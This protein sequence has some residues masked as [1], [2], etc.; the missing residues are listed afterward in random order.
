MEDLGLV[1]V[2]G[3]GRPVRVDDQGPAPAV[4]DDLVVERTKQARSPSRTWCRRGPCAWCGAPGRRRRAGCSRRPTGSAGPAA[5]PRCGSPPGPSRRTRYPAAGSA[6]PAA[7][8]APGAAGSG[9]P[10]RPGDQVHRLADDRLLQGGPG[11][12]PRAVPAPRVELDAQPDQI[13]ER[14]DVDV[15]GDDRGH[16]GVAGDGRGGVPVQPRAIAGARLGGGGAAGGP[17]LPDLRGP[18]VLQGR[19]GVEQDQVGQG[20]VRPGFDRL[21]GPLGQQPAAAS[22]RMR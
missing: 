14:V 2:P 19:V 1:L 10:A 15:A 16:G 13:I 5:A 11:R 9:Q 6:R 3:G 4:D 20:D 22:R 8:P 21:P 18:F 17:P 7:P 12:V